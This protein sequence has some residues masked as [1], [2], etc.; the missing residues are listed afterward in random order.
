MVQRERCRSRP[1]HMTM[2]TA[3]APYMPAAAPFSIP[4]AT[5]KPN[6]NG[7]ATLQSAGIAARAAELVVDTP[8]LVPRGADHEEAAQVDDP[9]ALPGR[10]AAPTSGAGRGHTCALTEGF[11]LLGFESFTNPTAATVEQVIGELLRKGEKALVYLEDGVAP[12]NS[13]ALAQVRRDGLERRGLDWS[14]EEETAFRE[15]IRE[16]YEHQGHPYYASARLW[17]DGIIDPAETRN[18]L[19]LGLA[20]TLNAPIEPTRFGVFRM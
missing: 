2:P 3:I 15:P 16:Q 8:A 1:S 4:D 9:L 20:A 11:A 13:R 14:T 7:S 6:A 17:D 19:G 10:P 5:P 12:P 18:V